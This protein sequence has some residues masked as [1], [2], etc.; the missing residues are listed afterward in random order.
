MSQ[1][2]FSGLVR[3]GVPKYD[4]TTVCEAAGVDRQVGDRLWRGLG[5]PDVPE[6]VLAYTDDD[7]R[8]LRLAAEGLADLEPG[9]RE[10]ALALILQ[11][12]RIL[13][14]HLAALCETELDVASDLSQLGVRRELLA[15]ALRDGIEDSDLGWL[16]FYVLRR[17]LQA[18]IARRSSAGPGTE[19][20]R[21]ELTLGFVDLTGFTALTEHRHLDDIARILTEFEA[22]AFDV[23][24]ESG[25]RIVKLIGD[26]VMFVGPDPRAAVEAALEVVARSGGSLPRARAALAHG[27]MLR[28]AGDYFGQ[29]VNRASRMVQVAEP[30]VVIVDASTR[31]RLVEDSEILTESLGEVTLRGLGPIEL[32]RVRQQSA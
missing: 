29:T 24:A 12:A 26:E 30:G 5:F 1:D 3:L 15:G 10:Q 20:G 11:E 7:A 14:A 16:I 9:E 31:E 25:G 6:G 4:P 27:N 18:T 28:R 22:L 32:W 13:S 2:P 19:I 17:E 21:D 23:V 8:A